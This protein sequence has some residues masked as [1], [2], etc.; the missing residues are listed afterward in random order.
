MVFTGLNGCKTLLKE[1]LDSYT[2]FNNITVNTDTLSVMAATLANAGIC[3]VTGEN[4]LSHEGFVVECIRLTFKSFNSENS[5]SLNNAN[6]RSQVNSIPNAF[7]W[8]E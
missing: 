6:K 4:C 8:N 5:S 1:A 2:Q 3:P 7:S